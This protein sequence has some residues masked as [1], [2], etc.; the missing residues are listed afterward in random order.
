MPFSGPSTIAIYGQCAGNQNGQ[1]NLWQTIM[2]SLGDKE[3]KIACLMLNSIDN[4]VNG[5][6]CDEF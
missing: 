2:N 5:A 3:G 1:A 4:S 6:A